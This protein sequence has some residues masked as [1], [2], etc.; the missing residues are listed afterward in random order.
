MAKDPSSRHS[1]LLFE[2]GDPGAAVAVAIAAAAAAAAA[3]AGVLVALTVTRATATAAGVGAGTSTPIVW[4]EKTAFAPEEKRG[5]SLAR[6]ART[7]AM[8]GEGGRLPVV[9]DRHETLRCLFGG[10]LFFCGGCV[11]G[12][13]F[14]G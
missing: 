3:A 13:R 5:P 10:W 4:M 2:S 11:R 1:P 6:R 8:R 9:S 12:C 7:A 14:L